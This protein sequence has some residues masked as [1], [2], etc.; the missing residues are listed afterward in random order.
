M[1]EKAINFNSGCFRVTDII[2]DSQLNAGMTIG[3]SLHDIDNLAKLLNIDWEIVDENSPKS[4]QAMYDEGTAI[5]IFR[6]GAT[7]EIDVGDYVKKD[8]NS[9]FVTKQIAL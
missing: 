7:M 8:S 6:N 9:F 2:T 4:R 1:G 5:L 3:T